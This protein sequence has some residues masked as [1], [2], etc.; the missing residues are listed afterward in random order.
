MIHFKD[1]EID[2]L[3]HPLNQILNENSTC[4]IEFSHR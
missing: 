4:P 3:S 1:E 2:N